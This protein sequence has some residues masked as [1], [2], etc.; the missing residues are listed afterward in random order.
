MLI[1]VFT[2]EDAPHPFCPP[3]SVG[4]VFLCVPLLSLEHRTDTDLC[5][6]HSPWMEKEETKRK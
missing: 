3:R 1:P 4:S 2:G 5:I 6:F